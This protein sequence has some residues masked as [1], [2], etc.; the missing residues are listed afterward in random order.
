MACPWPAPGLYLAC[1]WPTPGLRL[2]CA[3]PAPG[4]YLAYAWP[5]PGPRLA[6]QCLLSIIV[7]SCWLEWNWQF[8]IHTDYCCHY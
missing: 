1:T 8:P 7:D 2:A 6:N 5:V 4:L 3:W